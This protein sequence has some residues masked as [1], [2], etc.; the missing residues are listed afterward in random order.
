MDCDL[1]KASFSHRIRNMKGVILTVITLEFSIGIR[2][3]LNLVTWNL[4]RY[5]RKYMACCSR[6]KHQS[7]PRRECS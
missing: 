2:Y 4:V 7:S 3:A 5:K 1:P 6:W